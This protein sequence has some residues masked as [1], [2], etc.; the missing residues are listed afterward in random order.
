MLSTLADITNGNGWAI[1]VDLGGTKIATVLV[2][3]EGR[4]LA[5]DTRPTLPEEGYEAVIGRIVASAEATLAAGDR[6]SVGRGDG[7][8]GDSGGSRRAL[9]GVGVGSPGPIERKTGR[10]LFAP[11]LRWDDVPIVSLLEEALRVPV[12]LDNDANLA[13]F[14]EA[15][16]GAAR[17]YENVVYITVSTGIGGGVIAG[18]QIY[19]GSHDAAGEVGHM[20]IIPDGPV[21]GCGNRGC[22]EALASGTAIARRARQGLEAG[23]MSSLGGLPEITAREVAEA[24]VAGDGFARQIVEETAFYLGIGVGNLIN[25]FDP[26]IVVIGGGVSRIGEP[27]FAPLR[28]EAEHRTIPGIRGRARIEPAGLGQDSGVLGA[29]GLALDRWRA[30]G[31]EPQSSR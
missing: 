16:Y 21:C 20:T 13:G 4:I 1:G 5:R 7:G 6:A 12:Y 18:G 10:V 22:W 9:V 28:V 11:N 24:A 27:L 29:A 2:D 17:G 30:R 25:L 8:G 15:R 14:G 3:L 19:H 26:D 31:N 23:A